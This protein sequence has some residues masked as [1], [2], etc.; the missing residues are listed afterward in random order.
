VTVRVPRTLSDKGQELAHHFEQGP[1]GGFASSIYMDSTGNPTIGWGHLVLPSERFEIPMSREAADSLFK[2]DVG[3]AEASTNKLLDAI[4]AVDTQSQ[5]DALVCLVFNTGA[6]KRDKIKGDVADS[7]LL[8]KW[9]CG[10]IQGAADQFLAWNKGRVNGKLVALGGLT[11]RRK[12]ERHLFL[13]D[14]LKF[15]F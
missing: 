10:D 14:A 1:F 11:R 7:T 12:A 6:G 15:Q 4:K 5:F 13:H 9:E 8:D 3:K 2:R